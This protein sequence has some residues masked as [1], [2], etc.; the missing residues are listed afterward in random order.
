MSNTKHK[1]SRDLKNQILERI[2]TSGKSIKE[3]SDEHGI[4]KTTIYQWLKNGVE[5][6]T[7]KELIKLEKENRELKQIIGEL[8][9]QL[10]VGQ[11]R[12]WR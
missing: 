12:G 10:G 8:T 1:V 4:S 3:I 11:K 2:K 7:S 9:V 6:T 5:G